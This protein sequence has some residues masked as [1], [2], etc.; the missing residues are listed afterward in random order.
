MTITLTI[1]K[2]ILKWGALALL[3]LA[4]VGA[5][6]ALPLGAQKTAEGLHAMPCADLDGNGIVT[7]DDVN[8]V[9]SY[10]NMTVPP[11]PPEADMNSDGQIDLF[12]DLNYVIGEVGNT[13]GCQDSPIA[14]N[15]G[16]CPAKPRDIEIDNFGQFRLPKS[17]FDVTDN[18]QTYL[19]TV[20]DND[21]QGAPQNHAACDDGTDTICDDENSA[22]G[23]IDVAVVQGNYNVSVSQVP[24]NHAASSS[25]EP[26]D[27]TS[28]TFGCDLTFYNSNTLGITPWFPWDVTGG[29]APPGTPS[30]PD[31]VVDLSNDILGVVL[32]YQDTK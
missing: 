3:V 32:H 12:N 1:P 21:F 14:C 4:M 28:A 17:C 27:A 30:T 2:P 13:T 25:K 16:P 7:L 22:P 5:L 10:F 8:I 15:G 11:G 31:G 20:C 6:M 19:F 29:G 9:Q 26:C 24:A 23:Q 18:V